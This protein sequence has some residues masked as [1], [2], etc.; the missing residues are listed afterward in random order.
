MNMANVKKTEPT[1]RIGAVSRLTGVA[2][3]KLRVWER[4]YQAVVPFRSDA[5]TCLYSREDVVRLAMMKYLVDRGDVIGRLANLGR[6]QL[7]ERAKG[8]PLGIG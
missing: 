8:T 3:D 7:Q 1:Y 5:G 2:P 4:R 6:E